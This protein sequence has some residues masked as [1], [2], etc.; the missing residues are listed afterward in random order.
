MDSIFDSQ[1]YNIPNE[2]ASV[3]KCSE[4][5][6]VENVLFVLKRNVYD[7]VCGDTEQNLFK[8]IVLALAGPPVGGRAGGGILGN[9]G[10]WGAS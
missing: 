4:H 1:N 8:P 10:R 6:T 2:V 3:A 7:A 9:T 5:L